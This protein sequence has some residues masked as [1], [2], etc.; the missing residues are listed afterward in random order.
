MRTKNASRICLKNIGIYSIAG[1]AFFFIGYNLMY[2][3]VQAVIGTVVWPLYGPSADEIALMGGDE[4][5]L[6]GRDRQRLLGDV[7]LVLPDGVRRD[8]RVDHLRRD[9]RAGEDVELLPVHPPDHRVHLPD[10]WRVDLGRRLAGGHGVPGLRRFDHRAQHRRLGGAGGHPCGG[11]EAGQVPAATA[12]F[13][14]LR[15]P[16]WCW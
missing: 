14:R 7:R 15:R 10:S 5:A 12:G 16:T 9:G 3:N 2:S 4:S 6:A 11:A 8:D 13:A 1:L